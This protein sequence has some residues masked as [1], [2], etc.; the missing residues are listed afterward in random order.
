MLGRLDPNFW[1]DKRVFLTG[2]TGF[3]G[4]WLAYW[5]VGMGAKVT[6]YALAPATSPALYDLLGLDQ[7]MDSIIGDIRN[8]TD[9]RAALESARP[10]VV[11][12][13]AAQ[14][15]V[16][17]GYEAP[18]E[19]FETNVMGVVHLLDACRDL[20]GQV[21]VLIISSDKCYRNNDDGHAFHVNDPLGGHDPYSAS[22]A[23]TEIVV[24]A[25]GASYFKD[26]DGPILASARAGN[27]VGGGDWSLNRLLPDG[28]RAFAAGTPL[29]LR[30]P[31]ATR[32]WQHVVEPLYGYLV[33]VQAMIA[34]RKFARA[35]NFGPND[36]NHEAVGPL[37]ELFA[38]AW[39]PNAA[40]QISQN[41]QNWKEAATL[42][43]DCTETF[44][45]LAWKPVLDLQATVDWTAQWYRDTYSDMSTG[46]VRVRTQA[47]IDDYVQLQAD[48][49]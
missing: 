3:K 27:V 16:S 12:H 48:R 20:N 49:P 38:T 28:A 32:P 37:A 21:P 42:D 25:Y 39:G 47:Q 14:P 2:H 35:W 11:L 5:L 1:Q 45:R 33:L 26:A 7:L 18:V 17:V 13:L 43:L 44:E 6:G 36:R 40:V 29:V 30:N 9:V 34:D 23:G 24:G 10:E 15:I 8:A 19:T 4:A 41:T 46:A 31:L 22:K